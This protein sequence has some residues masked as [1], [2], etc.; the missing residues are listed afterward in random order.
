MLQGCDVVGADPAEF[1][2]VQPG[3]EASLYVVRRGAGANDRVLLCERR[4][5]FNGG[6]VYLPQNADYAALLED[7]KDVSVLGAVVG[8]WLA[9]VRLVENEQVGG[10]E[11]LVRNLVAPSQ[12][13]P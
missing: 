6:G 5:L 9:G 10:N 4:D 11:C 13:G 2:V 8:R 12:P 1:L 3:A 7:G